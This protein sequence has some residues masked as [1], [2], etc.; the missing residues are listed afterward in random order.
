MSNTPGWHFANRSGQQQG[1]V[2][3]ADLRAAFQRGELDMNTLVWRDGL[4][5]WT[6]LAQLAGEIG[7]SAIAPPPLPAAAPMRA[8]AGVREPVGYVPPPRKAKSRSTIV[9]V[10][11]GVCVALL[12]P[13][14]IFA[15]I[16]ISA[17]QGYVAKAQFAEAMSIAQSIEGAVDEHH[18]RAGTCPAT[19]DLGAGGLS[20]RYVARV[21]MPGG[22]A[23]CTFVAVFGEQEPVAAPLRGARVT[24]TS[25]PDGWSCR[26]SL[27]DNIK[28]TS[29]RGGS[30]N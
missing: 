18:A 3:T 10:I 8:P 29:C 7:L 12:V 30:A 24:F 28:P 9:L 13:I 25:N 15:A 11:I 14:S 20:G 6:P 23:P 16:A 17:Y 2:S 1:P 26:S 19:A 22:P 5:Q 27:P 21:E 4:A